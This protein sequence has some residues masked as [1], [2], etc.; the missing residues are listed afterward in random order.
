MS[1]VLSRKRRK[2]RGSPEYHKITV[3]IDDSYDWQTFHSAS[4][5]DHTTSVGAW[6]AQVGRERVKQIQRDDAKWDRQ[7]EKRK[8]KGAKAAREQTTTEGPAP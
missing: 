5:R 1:G 3:S 8:A 2:I 4:V 7:E 6:L